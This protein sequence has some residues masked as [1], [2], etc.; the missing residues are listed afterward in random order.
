M[1]KPSNTMTWHNSIDKQPK[2]IKTKKSSDTQSSKKVL[3][4]CRFNNS[5]KAKQNKWRY[6]FGTYFRTKDRV[7]PDWWQI[8]GMMGNSQIEVSHWAYIKKPVLP[9]AAVGAIATK[10]KV[11][12][13]RLKTV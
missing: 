7:I 10:Y 2:F 1:K 5:A 4:R 9:Q 12:K 11:K 6:K 8:E 13:S 3:V